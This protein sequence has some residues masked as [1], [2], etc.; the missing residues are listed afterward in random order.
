MAIDDTDRLL[1][2]LSV[3]ICLGDWELLRRVRAA[4]PEGQPDRRWRE[5]CLQ[6]HLFAGMPRVVE[7]WGVLDAAGGLGEPDAEE[8]RHEADRFEAGHALFE[9][10][11]GPQAAAVRETLSGYHPVLERWI[12]GH[13]YGRVLARPGLSPDRR[14]IL[15]VACLSAL[16]QDRQLASH[17]RG[18]VFVGATSE[19]LR[20]ALDA[21][22]DLVPRETLRH[23]RR[24]LDRF[25]PLSGPR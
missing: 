23:A 1:V 12:E 15:A 13:A 3:G 16:G 14:E 8:A 5:A 24:V 19:E 7:A 21:V 9:R 11:Y 2:R 4:A 25:A 22:E 20:E 18:A 10:I 17:A 6:A